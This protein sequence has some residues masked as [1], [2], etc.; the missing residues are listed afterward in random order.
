MARSVFTVEAILLA[1]AFHQLEWSSP[2]RCR[3]IN[4]S[5]RGH[6]SDLTGNSGR[7]RRLQNRV[8]P[9]QFTILHFK[10]SDP[11]INSC[12]RPGREVPSACPLLQQ[13]AFCVRGTMGVLDSSLRL[14]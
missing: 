6:A 8:R 13:S 1:V 11:L 5:H 12:R 7:G 10:P 9:A 2:F 4:E 3:R 14:L